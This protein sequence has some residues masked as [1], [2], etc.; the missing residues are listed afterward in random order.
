MGGAGGGSGF[1]G[2]RGMINGASG[3]TSVIGVGSR[4]WLQKVAALTVAVSLTIASVDTFKIAEKQYHS[5][6]QDAG[7]LADAVAHGMEIRV[8]RVISDTCLWLAQAQTLIRLFP[9]HKEK[10]MIKWTAFAL[11]LLDVIFSI[12][13]SFVYGNAKT[14]PRTFVNTVPAL[15]YLF[16]IALSIL[17][18]AW[19][20]YY[21]LSKRR[22]AFFHP[23]MRNIC[24]M[25]V[26]SLTS[27][28]IPALF[29][30]LDIAKPNVSGWGNYVRWVGAAAAS[31]VVWE[32]VERIEALERDENK[33]GILGREIFDGDEMLE[34]ARSGSG[35]GESD[36]D[37]GGSSM[38]VEPDRQGKNSGS[39][40]TS[41]W[42]G[43]TSIATRLGRSHFAHRRGCE[44]AHQTRGHLPHGKSNRKKDVTGPASRFHTQNLAPPPTTASP[45][46]RADTASAAS[47]VYRIHYHPISLG[48]PPIEEATVVTDSQEHEVF[49]CRSRDAQPCQG[50]RGGNQLAAE[51]VKPRTNGFTQP[52]QRISSRFKRQRK[53][54]PAEVSQA[55]SNRRQFA[56]VDTPQSYSNRQ[57]SNFLNKLRHKDVRE[58]EE[59]LPVT[60]IPW[61]PRG[62]AYLRSIENTPDSPGAVIE[63][64]VRVTGEEEAIDQ[65]SD[66]SV[67]IVETTPQPPSADPP[68]SPNENVPMDPVPPGNR[69]LQDPQR[70]CSPKV[71]TSEI[72]PEAA[73]TPSRN[74]LPCEG[75][76]RQDTHVSA[77]APECSF[78]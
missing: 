27:I 24:L 16:T 37:D 55:L 39:G 40:T 43:M 33:D 69:R 22:F 29:F 13:N 50:D 68:L 11:I 6:F 67:D 44:P 2:R 64:P 58:A 72:A 48:H 65:L 9:R 60:V 57:R 49:Q 31:V 74:T 71:S 51:D 59:A 3:S 78:K 32:W 36:D 5:G 34:N 4:P 54:P 45:V 1:L 12:L 61:Q 7:A 8:V 53:S 20:L 75:V 52:L 76:L 28:V 17:Y 77:S 21:A 62:S 35:W 38:V 26:L 19:V 63:R 25:A 70:Q 18:M 14:R 41:G 10:V 42:S 15:N 23:K 30:V 46:S 66:A 56:D 73:N 47:T